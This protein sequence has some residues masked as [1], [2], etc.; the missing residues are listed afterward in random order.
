MLYHFL[1]SGAILPGSI[2]INEVVTDPR[3]DWSSVGFTS[4]PGP[5][6][7]INFNDQWIEIYN[8]FGS[9]VNLTDWTITITDD[10]PSV[11]TIGSG[12]GVEIFSTGS[13]IMNFLADGYLVIGNPNG[14]MSDV[15]F[16]EL[17]D[18]TGL[19]INNV[20]I[21]NDPEGDGDDDVA[22]MGTSTGILDEA[23][24]RFPNGTYTDSDSSDF[25]KRTATIGEEN[26]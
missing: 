6:G 25:E 23:V 3:Q 11:H 7:I 16:I 9:A 26:L 20:E 5:G 1:P 19:L 17:R 12:V 2:V 13:S 24:T 18:E 14:E 22:P 15:V 4:A 10:T 8:A 21:G